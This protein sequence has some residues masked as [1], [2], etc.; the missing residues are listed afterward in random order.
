MQ[1]QIGKMVNKKRC[2]S[3][4]ENHATSIEKPNAAAHGGTECN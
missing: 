2:F 4:S 3:L 1:T